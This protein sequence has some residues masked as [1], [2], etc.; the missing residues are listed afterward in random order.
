MKLNNYKIIK[1]LAETNQSIIYLAKY[2]NYD[3]E[4]I[5]K[6]LN[7][8]KFEYGK[9]LTFIRREAE[10]LRK[11]SHPNIVKF[12]DYFEEFNKAYLVLE[13][14]NG[15]NINEYIKTKRE[16]TFEE[17]KN[18]FIQMCSAVLELH[19]FGIIHKDIKPSNFLINS[20]GFVKLIDLG[21]SIDFIKQDPNFEN[22]YTKEFASPEQLKGN[23]ILDIRT[24][25]YSLGKTFYF[26]LTGGKQPEPQTILIDKKDIKDEVTEFRDPRH[27]N[28]LIPQQCVEIIRKCLQP[29]RRKRYQSVKLILED[30]ENNSED[31]DELRDFNLINNFEG[32]FILDK[33]LDNNLKEPDYWI[34]EIK[35]KNVTLKSK[36]PPIITNL[37]Y[38][39]INRGNPTLC[40]IKLAKWIAEEFSD[41]VKDNSDEISFKFEIYKK[42]NDVIKKINELLSL[43]AGLQNAFLV[44]ISHRIIS[45]MDTELIF[46]VDIKYQKWFKVVID[47]FL[48]LAENYFILNDIEFNRPDIFI[49]N[50]SKQNAIKF[51]ISENNIIENGVYLYKNSQKVNNYQIK[52]SIPAP[53]IIND[54]KKF[55]NTLIY[56]LNN[57]FRFKNFRIGQ[58][59]IISRVL[60]LKNTVGLLPTGAGKSLCYQII[61]F[62]QPAP[63][64]IIEPIKSLIVDQLYNLKKFF[65]D[66]V[67]IITSDQLPD[68]RERIQSEFS[69]GKFLAI[70]V[71]PERFQIDKFRSY[72]TTLVKNFPIAYAVIDE[73]HCVSEWGH[74]FRTSYLGLAHTIRKYCNHF[75]FIPT[76]YA[77][78][79][80]ASEIVLKDILSDLEILDDYKNAV[81]RNY[82][83]DRKELYFNVYK[84]SSSEKFKK[85]IAIL[86]EIA[87]KIGISSSSY[88]F[89]SNKYGCGII[90]CPHV[91][92]TDYSVSYLNRKLGEYYSLELIGVQKESKVSVSPQC[93]LCGSEMRL[94]VNRQN[95]SKFWGC[96]KFPNCRGTIDFSI[97]EHLYPYAKEDF[98][99]K[100][101]Y[102]IGMFSGTPIKGFE[103]R[104]WDYYKKDIQMKFIEDK[105]SCMIATKSFGMGIDKL[106][107]RYTIHYN[108]PQSIESFYQEAGRAGR[109]GKNAYC[110]IIFSD[111]FPEIDDRFLDISKKADELWRLNHDSNSDIGRNLFFQ[112]QSYRGEI[113]EKNKIKELLNNF[114]YQKLDSI[115][116][117]DSLEIVIPDADKNEKFLFRLKTFGLIDD[118][119]IKYSSY[120]VDLISLIVIKIVKLNLGE[121][122][123]NLVNYFKIRNE[124]LH[125][126]KIEAEINKLNFSNIKEEIEYCIDKVISFVYEKIEPQRRAS[127]RNIVDA[128]RSS[129]EQEFRRKVLRYLSPDEDINFDFD[130]F[131]NSKN[132]NNWLEIINKALEKNQLDKYLGVTLR[133]LESYPQEPGLLYI[134]FTIRMLLPEEN[135]KLIKEDLIAFIRFYK[136]YFNNR[137]LDQVLLTILKTLMLHSRRDD[138]LSNLVKI[139]VKNISDKTELI[140]LTSIETRC[141]NTKLT[142]QTIILAFIRGKLKLKKIKLGKYDKRR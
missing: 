19:K 111:D 118:Y 40:S 130:I 104:N 14:I 91:N 36:T 43:A 11:L 30:L 67:N 120:N 109:D 45:L 114:I 12:L 47:D 80:T 113:E 62:L 63:I 26:L 135:P 72:L 1:K 142:L 49:N 68:E 93:P 25:I 90:F 48:D 23:E 136:I 42:D 55:D 74:D 59:E 27:F 21:I 70:Y 88:L 107:V 46:N 103:K 75:G 44:L 137:S 140:K 77:L 98:E 89:K 87:K 7:L 38:N 94:R 17:A 131:P 121:Y 57:I 85:L 108:L 119:Y 116:T 83:F 123:K 69:Q 61:M 128:C 34:F 52:T 79:G 139:I 13:Y 92:S 99:I 81:I 100:H 115:Q 3:S 112:K 53:Y 138:I 96:S 28:S 65:I 51:F 95:K 141:T 31:F 105:I 102:G 122:S 6:E 20:N 132:Y 8:N 97:Y 5:I 32:K 134:S 9:L 101:Y 125:A 10:Y 133:L 29:D 24:D 35:L 66:K 71:S 127:L 39:Y 16:I 110:Y 41:F 18:I 78:T 4:V 33:N 106:N 126:E 58:K 73:A 15:L 76:F 86:D 54:Q 129:S 56:F 2:V 50:S 64:I 82:T 22:A 84:C 37:M 60:S 117:L 124:K